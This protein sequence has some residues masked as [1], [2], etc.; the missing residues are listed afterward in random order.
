M[1]KMGL[2]TTVRHT[3]LDAAVSPHQYAEKEVQ[4]PTIH[5]RIMNRF[6]MLSDAQTAWEVSQV[7]LKHVGLVGLDIGGM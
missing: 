5:G 1:A 4:T 3:S 6:E 7:L 2:E